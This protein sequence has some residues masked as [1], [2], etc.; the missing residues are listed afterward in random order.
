MQ[1]ASFNKN[2]KQFTLLIVIILLGVFLFYSL[3][4]FF[5]AFLGSIIFYI[6]TK[7]MVNKLTTKRK[8]SPSFSAIIIMVFSFF[9]ILLPISLFV[10]LLYGKLSALLSNPAAI[11][12]NIRSIDATIKAKT[13]Y[14]ILSKEMMN[15]IPAMATQLLGLIVNTGVNALS[16]VAMMYFFLYFLLT[17]K[18]LA[19]Q[20]ERYL[21]FEPRHIRILST[22][23]KQ[24]TFSNA[25]AIPLIAV[26]Q[27]LCGYVAYLIA[28]VP[29]AGLWGV[30][31]GFASIIPVVGSAV[32]YIPVAIYL[33]IVGQVW[34]GV[35]VL[36][37]CLLILG[38]VDNVIRFML[39][40]KM[41]DVHPII[42]VLGVIMGLKYFGLSGLIFGPLLISYFFIFYKMY[43]NDYIRDPD[44]PEVE[45][46]KTL[47]EKQAEKKKLKAEN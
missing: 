37:I 27:G 21:P 31:T 12:G 47:A 20:L 36:A 22:E 13:G 14:S 23:L 39:A 25:L 19:Q 42:T 24:Q 2:T 10:T 34:Q 32:I 17:N 6:L 45:P 7:G 44:Q 40:K 29:E 5:T 30:L 26:A 18:S 38:T 35:T 9:V 15:R 43:Y 11:L 8:L 16:S 46:S 1:N 3:I 4:E 28:G 33:F 41:A